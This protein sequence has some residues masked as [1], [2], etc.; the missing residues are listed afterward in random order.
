MTELINEG[1]EARYKI[2]TI[3]GKKDGLGVENLRGSGMVAGETSQAYDEVCTIS[4]VGVVL[5]WWVWC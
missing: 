4:M 1:G 5:A 3:I 2:T